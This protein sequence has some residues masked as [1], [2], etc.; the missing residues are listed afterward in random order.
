MSLNTIFAALRG[1]G[2]LRVI[3]KEAKGVTMDAEQIEYEKQKV[4]KMFGKWTAHNIHLGEG[5]YTIGKDLQGDEIKLRRIVQ[6]ITDLSNGLLH[7]LRILDLACLEG[8][9]GIE[10][11]RHG[12]QVVGIEGRESNLEKAQLSKRILNLDNIT[13]Y[14]DDVRNLN[15]A[16]YGHFDVVLCYC[17]VSFK[18]YILFSYVGCLI[19]FCGYIFFSCNIYFFC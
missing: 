4:V 18:C 14:K 12:A 8:L 10:L 3:S 2:P 1:E 7:N 19:Y 11:A 15:V 17:P 5:V 9:Y 13:I 6:I 16:K